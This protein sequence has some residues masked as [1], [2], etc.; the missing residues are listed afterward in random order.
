M[1]DH[2]AIRALM[3]K[4]DVALV[5][6][7]ENLDE[8]A[9]GRLVE[10]IHALMAEFYSANLA[11][12]VKKGMGQ[13][14]KLGGYP[15]KAPLGYLNIREQIGTRQVAHIVVDP[16]RAPLVR[17]AFELYATGDWTVEHLTHELADRGLTNRGRIDYPVKSVTV[18]GMARLLAN[19][20]YTG[21]VVW[22]EVHYPGTHEP[23]V[24]PVTFA[25]VQELLSAKAMRGTRERKHEHYL[26][27]LLVCGVC[28]RKLSIQR[29]KGTYV[30]FYCLGQKDR[31]N[32]TGCQESYVAA[33][34]LEAEVESLYE[35]IQVPKGW[36]DGLKQAVAAEVA[37]H[38]RDTTAERA[39]LAK[40]RDRAEAERYKLMEAYYANAID[41]TMLRSEQGRIGT[42]LRTN[43]ARQAVLDTSLDDW[44][45][46]MNTA[47][48]FAT[49]CGRGYRRAGDR[50]RKLYNAAVLQKVMVRDGHVTEP[51]YQ[52]PFDVLFS[53][54]RFEYGTAVGRRGLEPL[55]LAR[56]AYS[57]RSGRFIPGHRRPLIRTSCS[58]SFVAVHSRSPALLYSLLY[59][60]ILSQ[61]PKVPLCWPFRCRSCLSQRGRFRTHSGRHAIDHI[62]A[63]ICPT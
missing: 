9:S 30:Y 21:I 55:T 12:E 48:K 36:A 8:S 62:S 44:Q 51:E 56:H 13:K 33:D 45:G 5:S 14:A 10:G 15:H 63:R 32:G 26:K 18:S 52:E 47:L 60:H 24:D 61:T 34:Q 20:A 16:E 1:E 38:H 23:L 42:D 31:R 54:P 39:I 49:T 4:R 22:G 6:V 19:P 35:R 27:G 11:N 40:Q 50:T 59:T 7:T 17:Q 37:A 41:I 29:S 2:I 43:E 25:K 46:V 58:D 3:R 53:V 28:S 57:A